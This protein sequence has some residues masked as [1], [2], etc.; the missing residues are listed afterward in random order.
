MTGVHLY[1]VNVDWGREDGETWD[2]HASETQISGRSVSA[3]NHIYIELSPLYKSEKCEFD[4]F[5]VFSVSIIMLQIF[6]G[7]IFSIPSAV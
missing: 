3:M 5:F 7:T 4:K 6:Y 2:F 1:S